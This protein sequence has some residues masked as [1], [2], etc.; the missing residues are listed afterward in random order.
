[1]KMGLASIVKPQD[2]VEERHVVGARARKFSTE[3]GT[4]L[5]Y[6]EV[7]V[8]VP[9]GSGPDAVS[10]GFTVEQFRMEGS[11]H[12]ARLNIGDSFDATLVFRESQ[13]GKDKVRKDLLAVTPK[14]EKR[15]P[16]P[17]QKNAA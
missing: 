9:L 14:D 11:Q 8:L 2:R 5:D 12:A 1:M 16:Q 10:W 6:T 3:D 15:Q 13:V 17:P 7:F 4:T